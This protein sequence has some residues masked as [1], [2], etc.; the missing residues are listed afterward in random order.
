MAGNGFDETLSSFRRW[1]DT[2]ERKLSGD[3]ETDA[4]ELG[5]VFDVM[6]DYLGMEDPSRLAE[7]DLTRLLLDVYPRKVTVLNREDTA[8]TIPALRDLITYLADTD[9]ITPATAQALEREL[10]EIEPDFAD[11]VMDPANWGP[12][13]ATM[14]AMHRDGV[15]MND[16]AAVDRWITRHNAGFADAGFADTEADPLT[17]DDID[18][19]EAFDLP[20]VLAPIR[21]PD[22]AELTAL[23]SAAPL[24]TDLRDLAREVRET[25]V[26]VRDVD[27]LL[28]RLAVEAELVELDGD[29]LIPGDDVEWLDEP[30]DLDA[31]NYTFAQVLDTTLAGVDDETDPRAGEDLDLMGHGIAIVTGLFLGG[32]AGVPVAEL[33]ATLKSAAVAGLSPRAAERQW[34]ECTRAYGDPARLLLGQLAKLSA[35]TISDDVARLEPLALFTVAVKLED[36][37]VQVP[38]LPSPDQMTADDVVLVSMF[39]TE[40]DFE[41]E[42]ASWLAKR[43]AEDAARELLAVAARQG[44][45]IRSMTIPIVSRLGAAAEPAWREALDRPELRCYAKPA[46]LAQLADRDPESE[47]PAELKAAIEDLAWLVADNLG[48]LTR[49]DNEDTTIPF[50]TTEL[51]DAGWAV[52]DETLFETMARLEHPDAEAILTML[53]KYADNKKTAKAARRAAY[54]AASRRASRR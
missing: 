51:S 1:A 13:K 23:A 52:N 31:W 20:D 18:L 37:D 30:A 4:G 34:E 53:G 7:G 24:M 8:D 38:E 28:V 41:A 54:K 46:L 3:P 10:D 27:P 32:R 49:L 39:G 5:M 15:D 48:P 14:H 47:V 16:S 6:P 26:R 36:C 19:K 43:T 40:E 2:T 29:T 45:E 33:S 17:W 35:V 50:D 42:F 12:A 25:A 9:T 22:E 44:A 21:L 11:D